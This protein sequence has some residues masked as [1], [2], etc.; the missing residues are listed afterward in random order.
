MVKLHSCA[1]QSKSVIDEICLKELKIAKDKFTSWQAVA[2]CYLYPI[3]NT[4]LH[5]K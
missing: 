5:G 1:I 4:Y 3:F 2:C